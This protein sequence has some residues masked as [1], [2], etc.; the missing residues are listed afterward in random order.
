[1]TNEVERRK[2]S[3]PKPDWS[4]SHARDSGD[5]NGAI[6][7]HGNFLLQLSLPR[8]VLS[9][10][11]DTLVRCTLISLQIGSFDTQQVFEYGLL[12]VPSLLLP[13]RCGQKGHTLK[14]FGSPQTVLAAWQPG[15][16]VHSTGPGQDPFCYSSKLLCLEVAGVPS[17][18]FR[19]PPFNLHAGRDCLKPR[20]Q[21]RHAFAK[22]NHQLP[23]TLEQSSESMSALQ[24]TV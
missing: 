24:T 2:S 15:S 11:T 13:Q 19:P 14:L 17:S 6:T 18:S 16:S 4:A 23:V 5:Q 3:L 12:S 8:H 1:M 10:F 9:A 20:I 7:P 21:F 22:T